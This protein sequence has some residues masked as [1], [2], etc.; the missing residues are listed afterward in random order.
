MKEFNQVVGYESVKIELERIIDMMIHPEKYARLGVT[1]TK[2]LLLHGD[3]G[4]GKTLMAKCFIEASKRK[5]FTVRKDTPDGDFVKMIKQTFDDAKEVAPSIVFLDDMDKFANEDENH[6]NAEEFVTIQSCIDDV[7]EDEVFVLATANDLDNLPG[8]LLRSGR[9]DKKVML[10]NPTGKDAELIV[11]HYLE[12]KTVSDDVDAKE[13]ARLLD[14]RS[15]AALETVINEAGVYSGFAGKEK[16]DMSDVVRSFMRIVY[17]SPE[18]LDLKDSRYIRNLAVHEAGHA[19]V[20][21]VLEPESV[22]LATIDKHMG[23]GTGGFVSFQ[24][25]EN[26]FESKHFMENRIRECLAGRAATEVVFGT[27][28]LGT[29][30]DLIRAFSILRRFVD[31]YC[32]FG[33][34]FWQGLDS[35]EDLS[36]RKTLLMRT[37]MDRYYLQ[38]KRIIVE[39]REFLDKLT[40]SLMEKKVLVSRDIRNIKAGCTIKGASC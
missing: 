21:E 37:E 34:D 16:I 38:T 9:F 19:L 29:R 13:V 39:N 14:G 31:N 33:F 25:D 6:K 35:S 40:D 23:D 4:V 11:K 27:T 15:C 1:T 17:E 3:P 10:E 18:D 20:A 26:Y 7:K 8:S 22:T 32:D 5:A 12:N 28:D 2:G 30:S 24:N 36:K